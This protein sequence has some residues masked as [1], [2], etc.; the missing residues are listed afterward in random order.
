LPKLLQLQGV[1]DL[2]Q[3]PAIL[4]FFKRLVQE[5]EQQAYN[6]DRGRSSQEKD[7]CAANRVHGF[8]SFSSLAA[9][10]GQLFQPG[11]EGNPK[12]EPGNF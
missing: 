9:N 1:G 8:P 2:L 10:V 6:D 7:D 11:N 12:C 4:V 3:V 5:K